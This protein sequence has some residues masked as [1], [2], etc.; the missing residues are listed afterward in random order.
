MSKA[1]RGKGIRE[2][3]AHGRGKCPVCNRENVKVLFEQ[4]A[5]GQKIKICKTCK[6]AIKNGKKK[7]PVVE[8]AAVAEAPA[9][10]AAPKETPAAAPAAAP[11]AEAQEAAAPAVEA[12]AE[13]PA[14]A[15]AAEVP[16]T[17][18]SEA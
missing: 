14:A 15:D 9:P 16:A 2:L 7:L 4:D 11:A 8:V 18:A 17:E 1:H 13:T 3:F 12:P 10:V 5:G 6:A